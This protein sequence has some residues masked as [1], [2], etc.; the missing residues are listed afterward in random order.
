M[1]R[2]RS[3]EKTFLNDNEADSCGS[4][5]LRLSLSI[6]FDFGYLDKVHGVDYQAHCQHLPP[7]E[8]VLPQYIACYRSH[9]EYKITIKG[10]HGSAQIAKPH[11]Y[12]K[13]DISEGI[14]I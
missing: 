9:D 2:V 10:H 8:P 11:G 14:K 5:L 13:I 1:Q 3:Y 6:V 4:A 12:K 7:A